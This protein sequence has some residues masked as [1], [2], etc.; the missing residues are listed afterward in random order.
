[1]A[2]N[3]FFFAL[4]LFTALYSRVPEHAEPFRYLFFGLEGHS[5]LVAFMWLSVLLAATAMIALLIPRLREN[6]SILALASAAV[7][8]SIWIDK[9][10]GLIVAG[11]VPSP[12]G[13]VTPYAPTVSEWMIVFGIWALGALLLTVF[14]KIIVAV[15]EASE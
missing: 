2:A 5:G 15:R 3:V 4:E 6:E 7:F 1:M 13:T 9:G 8:V 10:L 14:C 11:F 12:L